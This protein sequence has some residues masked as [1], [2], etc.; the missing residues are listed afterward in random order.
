M[1]EAAIHEA[2]DDQDHGQELPQQWEDLSPDDQQLLLPVRSLRFCNIAA[3]SLPHVG[4]THAANEGPEWLQ[5]S[6]SSSLQ[7]AETFFSHMYGIP[8]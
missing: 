4:V 5:S 2:L 8:A 1:N 6:R 3:P 7:C